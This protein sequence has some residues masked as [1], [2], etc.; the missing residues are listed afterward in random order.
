MPKIGACAVASSTE[1]TNSVELYMNTRYGLCKT[2][3]RCSMGVSSV[4]PTALQWAALVGEVDTEAFV[5]GQEQTATKE[6]GRDVQ[7]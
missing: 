2:N 5:S 1:S 3:K 6:V 7:G 4:L